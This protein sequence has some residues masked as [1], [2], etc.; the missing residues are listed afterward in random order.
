M[1]G[2]FEGLQVLVIK[3]TEVKIHFDIQMTKTHGLNP[4]I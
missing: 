1:P 2:F 3:I 4:M